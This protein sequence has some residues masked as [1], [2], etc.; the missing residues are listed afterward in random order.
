MHATQSAAPV[1]NGSVGTA[2]RPR[3]IILGCD[4]TNNTL[5]GG[6]HDTNVLKLIGQLAPEDADHL[7]YYDPGVGSPDQLP[8]VNLVNDLHRKW[9]RI[10]GLANGRGIYENIAE[11]YLFLVDHYQPGDQIY[12]FGFSRGAFT[13]RAVAGMINLFGIVTPHGRSLILTLIRV[14][15]S[16]PGASKGDIGFWPRLMAKK[17]RKSF[18]HNNAVAAGTAIASPDATA[19]QV[20][21]YLAHIKAHRNTREEIAGQ[22]RATFASADGAFA[23]V[24]F[25]GVW[26]TVESVG[27]IGLQRKITSNGGTLD[28][29]QFRHI[30]H[31]L[32]MDEH[33]R[34][35]APRLYW[36]EDYNQ[37]AGD[38][39]AHRSLRQ[40]WFRGVHSDVGGGY[41]ERE[42]G[43]SDQAYQWMLGEAVACGLRVAA[44]PAT[45]QVPK[46]LIAHDPCYDTPWWGVAGLTARSNVTHVEEGME[47]TVPVATEGAA[48]HP[49][50]PVHSVWMAVLHVRGR[51]TVLALLCMA[52]LFAC[53]GWLA[54]AAIAG[55]DTGI[56]L[57]SI[58]RGAMALEL[59]QK[60]YVLVGIGDSAPAAVALAKVKPAVEAMLVDFGLIAAYSW[61]IGLYGTLA[62]HAMAGRRNPADPAPFYYRLGNAP[63]YLV[64]ADIVENVFTLLTL[65]CIA[66]GWLAMSYWFGALMLVAGMV[67]WAGFLD[68][69]VLLVCG[70]AARVRPSPT[71]QAGTA[72]PPVRRRRGWRA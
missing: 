38:P 60:T 42:A 59:W 18:H 40:R 64:I 47:K 67:K 4:G 41:A 69:V 55:M 66:R 22:V 37:N 12:I 36:D 13:A 34:T 26:D 16:T 68:T 29:P 49:G 33:R 5:T 31:A 52:A 8:P 27:M 44:S 35:F 3:Q 50:M 32:S 58:A 23:P 57:A 7:L 6:S 2:R 70:I 19:A 48:Q 1:A 54:S 65:W 17:A 61:L 56:S 43:L 11:T 72:S 51:G 46:P 10:A 53:Y 14:Y 9:Q 28:K 15:F 25:V 30:R 62:F 45:A 39:A 63:M 21:R 24:H 71:L 20:G